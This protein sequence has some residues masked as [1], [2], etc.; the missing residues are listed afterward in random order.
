MRQIKRVV[1]VAIVS[2]ILIGC[3]QTPKPTE[4]R[5]ISMDTQTKHYNI[6]RKD[7]KDELFKG[8]ITFNSNDKY[9]AIE[10]SKWALPLVLRV[11]D[12]DTVVWESKLKGNDEIKFIVPTDNLKR[13]MRIKVENSFFKTILMDSE[14]K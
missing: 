10:N 9:I 13:G 4:T 14:I 5:A 8:D 2:S 6:G 7:S 11:M 12:G 3:H 1:T